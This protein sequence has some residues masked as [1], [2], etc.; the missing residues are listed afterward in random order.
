MGEQS[1]TSAI[2]VL[3]KSNISFMQITIVNAVANIPY[4]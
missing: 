4:T 2:L 1:V 3:L